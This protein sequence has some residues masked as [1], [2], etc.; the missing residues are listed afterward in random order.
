MI[1]LNLLTFGTVVKREYGVN[2]TA[3]ASS[4][5]IVALLGKLVGKGTLTRDEVR[6]VLATAGNAVS[7]N[8]TQMLGEKQ[9]ADMIANLLA[10]VPPIRLPGSVQG[11][12]WQG[13][14]RAASNPLSQLIQATQTLANLPKSVNGFFGVAWTLSLPAL[15]YGGVGTSLAHA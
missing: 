10:A 7:P 5:N 2:G 15:R 6:E 14:C 1:S 12:F 9:A 4:L 3:I 13:Q 8:F 11:G